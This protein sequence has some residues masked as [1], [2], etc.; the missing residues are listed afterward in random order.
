MLQKLSQ[1]SILIVKSLP[2]C[3]IFEESSTWWTDASVHGLILCSLFTSSLSRVSSPSNY[4]T[5]TLSSP[6]HVSTH[7]RHGQC[8]GQI[9]LEN[10][11]SS[12]HLHCHCLLDW[13]DVKKQKHVEWSVRAKQDVQWRVTVHCLKM[14][15]ATDQKISTKSNFK[16]LEKLILNNGQAKKRSSVNQ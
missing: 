13:M 2:C 6:A 11:I 15:N 8:Q 9:V 14:I 12:L 16:S 7:V 4:N 1:L 5:I 3:L 10:K